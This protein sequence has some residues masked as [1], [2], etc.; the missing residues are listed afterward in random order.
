MHAPTRQRS[1]A[2]SAA[3]ANS[4]ARS[5][6]AMSTSICFRN[7]AA[8]A[9]R[10]PAT[11]NCSRSPIQ[12]AAHTRVLRVPSL[13]RECSPFSHRSSA[14]SSDPESRAPSQTKAQAAPCSRQSGR[15]FWWH[16]PEVN[17][18]IREGQ[19]GTALSRTRDLE[20]YLAAQPPSVAEPNAQPRFF[21]KHE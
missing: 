10:L 6:T 19:V 2:G 12:S 3:P 16:T 14:L 20:K 11:P 15:I 18:G 5:T 17:P 4:R 9:Q 7:S 21:E 1:R 13:T 8:H